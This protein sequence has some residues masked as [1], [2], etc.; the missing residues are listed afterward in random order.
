MPRVLRILNRLIIGGPSRNAVYLSKYMQ[1]E[2][3]TLLVTGGKEDHEQDAD[4]LAMEHGITPY[5]ISE[6][7]RVISFK[8]DW[9]AYKKIK[10]LI[11]EFKPDIVHTHAAK[12]GALGR[13]AARQCNVPVI[14]HTFHG[15][16]FHS[17]FGAAKTNFYI[18]AERYLAKFTDSMIAIS[19]KQKEELTDTFRIAPA[20]KFHV[21][22]L[23]LHLEP[24]MHDQPEKRKHFRE[25][26]G[27][28]ENT[29]AIG[30]IGRLVPVK[31]HA[32][33]IKSIHQVLLQ[34]KS[35][36][37]LLSSGMAKAGKGLRI[38][39]WNWALIFV[40]QE[41]GSLKSLLFLLHGAPI[42]MLFVPGWI[43]FV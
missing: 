37:R 17:Y 28:D 36:L 34:T 30:I 2:F 23:G 14:V 32:L 43:L 11:R 39:R 41:H 16:V 3:E 33:Y 19:A 35:P 38:W 18:R 9:V 6:M 8:E 25:E 40:R 24:F 4:D 22:P 13:L 10:R 26:F 21:V 42:L 31:N 7:K 15:H 1:P 27:L 29:I 12:A 20:F 5:C